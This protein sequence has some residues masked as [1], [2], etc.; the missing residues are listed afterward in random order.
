MQKVIKNIKHYRVQHDIMYVR[1]TIPLNTGAHKDVSV[2][3]NIQGGI[4][5]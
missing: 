4:P 1:G 3:Q 5:L 2:L